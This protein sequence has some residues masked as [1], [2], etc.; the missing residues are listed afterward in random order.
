MCVKEVIQFGKCVT[1]IE[2]YVFWISN[3][4]SFESRFQTI[5]LSGIRVWQN[6]LRTLINEEMV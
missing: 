1:D 6:I 3:G 4:N 2:V 5:D